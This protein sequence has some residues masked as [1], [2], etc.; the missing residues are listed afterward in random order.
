M[1][2]NRMS[3]KDS[4]NFIGVHTNTIY[5]W[6]KEGKL[7]ADKE[8]K[9]YKINHMDVLDIY[10]S[11]SRVTKDKDTLV[12]IQNVKEETLEILN[13]KCFSLIKDMEFLIEKVTNLNEKYFKDLNQ[14]NEREKDI[15]KQSDYH[16]KSKSK[17]DRDI[18]NLILD[19]REKIE[20]FYDLSDFMKTLDK[21]YKYKNNTKKTVNEE[22]EL[23]KALK[24]NDLEFIINNV[25]QKKIF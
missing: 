2:D 20:S 19:L 11:K 8:G 1:P 3:V 16:F 18:L 15:I 9:N 24:N 22:L 7:R 14:F 21:M 13:T 4:A 23:T 12:S 17:L 25:T 5:E 10:S 6:I